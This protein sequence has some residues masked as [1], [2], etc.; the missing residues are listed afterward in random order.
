MLVFDA[1]AMAAYKRGKRY[2]RLCK[3]LTSKEVRN[4]NFWPY[5]LSLSDCTVAMSACKP[6]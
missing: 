5:L 1:G 3:M 4:R 6:V 2:K